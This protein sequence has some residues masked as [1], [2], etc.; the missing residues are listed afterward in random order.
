MNIFSQ[1]TGSFL[2]LFFLSLHK[3]TA[4]C[5]RTKILSGLFLSRPPPTG[6]RGSLVGRLCGHLFF[7]VFY[8][9]AFFSFFTTSHRSPKAIL[10]GEKLDFI[11][12]EI[13]LFLSSVCSAEQTPFSVEFIPL[14][15]FRS[16]NP[17]L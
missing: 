2:S 9:K 14:L 15:L 4:S 12:N 11:S 5:K 1:L 17:S 10:L 8:F 6:P 7:S 3:W 13:Q 16:C